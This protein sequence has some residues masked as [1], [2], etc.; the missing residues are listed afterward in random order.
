[1]DVIEVDYEVLEHHME[2]NVDIG[3]I[4][5]EVV[6]IVVVVFE[7]IEEDEVLVDLV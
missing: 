6:Y 2:H 7:H 5:E 3:P 1:M 4:E